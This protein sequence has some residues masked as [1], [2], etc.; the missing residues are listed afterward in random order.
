[1]ELGLYCTIYSTY[2]ILSQWCLGGGGDGSDTGAVLPRTMSA[3]EI[4]LGHSHNPTLPH[5]IISLTCIYIHVRVQW[6]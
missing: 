5:I 3:L 4:L 1:M 6:I 2:L